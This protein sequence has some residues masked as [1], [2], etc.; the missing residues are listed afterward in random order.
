MLH[1]KNATE[2]NLIF[3]IS[4]SQMYY[5][6]AIMKSEI[7]DTRLLSA[8]DLMGT[9]FVDGDGLMKRIKTS[10]K[11]SWKFVCRVEWINT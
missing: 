5:G 2:I 9:P 4:G 8:S 10:F 1:N 3:S 11:R 6:H 7:V